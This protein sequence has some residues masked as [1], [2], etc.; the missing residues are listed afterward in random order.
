MPATS[1]ADTWPV[2]LTDSDVA[3]ISHCFFDRLSDFLE[4][5]PLLRRCVAWTNILIFAEFQSFQDE[6][7]RSHSKVQSSF[8]LH[9]ACINLIT[10]CDHLLYGNRVT[11]YR[12]CR[13]FDP[14]CST[15]YEFR[16]RL[17][18]KPLKSQACS[19]NRRKKAL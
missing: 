7:A 10:M 16:A 14:W 12:E 4:F 8:K 1:S 19:Q 18:Y 3:C 9:Q 17:L 6:V 11:K 15:G 13:H 5:G 2:E